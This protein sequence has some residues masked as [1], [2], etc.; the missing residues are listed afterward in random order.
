MPVIMAIIILS[1]DLEDENV[2]LKDR[3]SLHRLLV[4]FFLKN[5][6]FIQLI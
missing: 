5:V 3:A 1:V 4:R 6:D 2:A